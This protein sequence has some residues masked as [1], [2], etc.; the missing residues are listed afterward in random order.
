MPQNKSAYFV[1]FYKRV[2]KF[3]K[4]CDPNFAKLGCMNIYNISNVAREVITILGDI[5]LI[6]ILRLCH[7]FIGLSLFSIVQNR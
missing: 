7:E 1:I 4:E 5:I 3:C 2:G 6:L